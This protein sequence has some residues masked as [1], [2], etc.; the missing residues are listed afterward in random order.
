VRGEECP[1]A[2]A[3]FE[4]H[5]SL[6]EGSVGDFAGH[7]T[8]E[9]TVAPSMVSGSSSSSGSGF[10]GGSGKAMSGTTSGP[11]LGE[12]EKM[13]TTTPNAPHGTGTT[14][15]AGSTASAM[16]TAAATAPD[17]VTHVIGSSGYGA[18]HS[19][20]DKQGAV[21]SQAMAHDA[22]AGL[23]KKLGSLALTDDHDITATGTSGTKAVTSSDDRPNVRP[24]SPH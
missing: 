5:R 16:G 22:A 6:H 18:H 3:A 2:K 9:S 19:N 23:N 20:V 14:P 15:T 12:K 10:S 13:V 11:S 4:A 1:I 24:P 17:K 7:S 8:P 21:I